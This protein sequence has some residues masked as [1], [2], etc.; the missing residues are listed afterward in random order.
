MT[1]PLH[2]GFDHFALRAAY[3]DATVRFCTE[4]I[5]FIRRDDFPSPS[6]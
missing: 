5:E 2:R 1:T 3:F 4:V 6:R